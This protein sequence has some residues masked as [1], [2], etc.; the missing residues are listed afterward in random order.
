[1]SNIL[2]TPI[3]HLRVITFVLEVKKSSTRWKGW[4]KMAY[5]NHDEES[6]GAPHQRDILGM[7][8]DQNIHDVSVIEQSFWE[9][10]QTL[11]GGRVSFTELVLCSF[12][13]D[14]CKNF[15]QIPK[16][17]IFYPLKFC[18][19]FRQF[20]L[21][22]SKSFIES[23]ARRIRSTARFLELACISWQLLVNEKVY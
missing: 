4:V 23:L 6:H 5:T 13:I 16:F 19:I 14:C 2:L 22:N 20:G 10:T 1:M 11:A 18:F 17:W 15:L 21:E 8:L 12:M 3:R 9:T 7:L